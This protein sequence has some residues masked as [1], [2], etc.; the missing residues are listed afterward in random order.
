[1]LGKREK[2]FAPIG[3]RNEDYDHTILNPTVLADYRLRVKKNYVLLKV[4]NFTQIYSI[5]LQ[6]NNI[7]F[8]EDKLPFNLSSALERFSLI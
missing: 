4:C 7:F 2:S 1:M 8:G 6:G 3:I 5:Y